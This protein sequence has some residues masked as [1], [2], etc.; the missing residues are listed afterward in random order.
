MKKNKILHRVYVGFYFIWVF[1]GLLAP[2]LGMRLN[3]K[4]TNINVVLSVILLVIS[5]IDL[6]LIITSD[7]FYSKKKELFPLFALIAASLLSAIVLYGLI[8]EIVYA[9]LG[10]SAI[11]PWVILSLSLIGVA[12]CDFYLGRDLLRIKNGL[13][14]TDPI[15]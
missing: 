2:L 4:G 15:K 5:L 14:E 12:A 6:A 3:G 8:A 10:E 9:G 11:Y 7:V 13:P 1:A